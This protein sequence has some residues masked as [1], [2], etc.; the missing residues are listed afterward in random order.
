[1]R[2]HEK[3]ENRTYAAVM[4]DDFGDNG[5]PTLTDYGE[6]AASPMGSD[7]LAQF[8]RSGAAGAVMSNAS[9]QDDFAASPY[10][11]SM[12]RTAG[13]KYSPAEQRELEA[14]FHPQGARNLPT[15]DDLEGT[16]YLL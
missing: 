16:H 12:L 1:M 4:S 3:A 13:R 8:H 10:V 15:D 9:P 11:Q 7:I 14:E 6:P 5:E 2:G